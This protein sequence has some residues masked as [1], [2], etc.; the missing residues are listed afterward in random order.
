MEILHYYRALNNITV[1][2]KFPIPLI[3]DLLF[4]LTRARYFT[5]PDLR[6][7]YHQVRMKEG[8]E[9]KT[10]Y[11][12]HQ[13][14]YEFKVMSFGLTNALATFQAFMNKVFK[15]LL[16]KTIVFFYDIIVYSSDLK[17]H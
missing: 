5:K 3:E 13:G 9:Y 14:M 17:E 12:T 8:E 4:V 2:N 11:K 6:V 10:A 15:P 7:G 16:R 1:K